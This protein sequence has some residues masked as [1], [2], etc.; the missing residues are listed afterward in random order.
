MRTPRQYDELLF[1]ARRKPTNKTSQILEGSLWLSYFSL[2]LSLSLDQT[3]KIGFFF[4]LIPL[5]SQLKFKLDMW[6]MSCHVSTF[7]QVQFWPEATHFAS[8]QVQ[9]TSHETNSSQFPTSDIFV[10]NIV[11]RSHWT[12]ITPKNVKIRQSRNLTK[13][14]WETRFYQTNPTAKSVL[15]S[16]IYKIS[17]FS[18]Y[19]ILAI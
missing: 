18:T 1:S 3:R 11:L 7:V 4:S 6:P 16:E 2:L 5:L 13:F 17:K 10:N 15:S 19:A 9:I 8:V 14:V 12:P